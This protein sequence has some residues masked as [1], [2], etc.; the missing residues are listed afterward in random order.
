[1]EIGDQS[2]P[3]ILYKTIDVFYRKWSYRNVVKNHG[4]TPNFAVGRSESQHPQ[5]S[6]NKAAFGSSGKDLL[7]LPMFGEMIQFDLFWGGWVETT[8]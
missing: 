7:F 2:T 8:N 1:M 5:M 3:L 6:T 4:R